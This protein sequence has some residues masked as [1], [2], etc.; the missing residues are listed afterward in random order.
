MTRSPSALL[1]KTARAD[2]RSH[3]HPGRFSL[4]RLSAAE[5]LAGAAGVIA[6]LWLAVYWALSRS[7]A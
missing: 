1:E 7:G 3:R 4:L 2:A 6:L 5:R